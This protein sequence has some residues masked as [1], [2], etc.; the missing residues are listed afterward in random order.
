MGGLLMG[1]LFGM[2]LGTGFGGGFG[3]L[4]LIFQGILIALLIGFLMR[5]FARRQQPA[6]RAPAI[7]PVRI[8]RLVRAKPRSRCR[9]WVALRLHPH[10][11]G[12]PMRSAFPM[13]IS[14]VS[15]PC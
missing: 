2:L 3:F 14:T 7:P 5:M 6:T 1:G 8:C 9:A 11:L 4:G 12:T 10:G 13:S 15:N